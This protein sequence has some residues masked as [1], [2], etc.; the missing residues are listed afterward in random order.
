MVALHPV[1]RAGLVSGASMT[2]G[3]AQQLLQSA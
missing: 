2:A 1:L 3:G